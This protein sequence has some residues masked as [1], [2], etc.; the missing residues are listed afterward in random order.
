MKKIFILIAVFSS[1]L[2][3]GKG[4]LYSRYGFGEINPYISARA[5]GMGNNGIALFSET[6]IN[7]E[8]PAAIGFINRSLF[9]GA[10]QHKT[11]FST[12]G[13]LSS[14]LLSGNIQAAAIAFPLYKPA[15]SVLALSLRPLSTMGYNLT[16]KSTL[17]ANTITQT[18]DGRG[19]LTS[20]QI[21][22]SYEAAEDI[23]LGGGLNYVFGAFSKDQT[24]NFTDASYFGGSFNETISMSGGRL[25]IG[26][27]IRGIDKMMQLSDERN[28]NVGFSLYS[29]TTL[30]TEN[31]ILRNFSS[32]TD[33]VTKLSLKSK[34]PLSVGLGISYSKN[35]IVYTGDFYFQNWDAGTIAGKSQNEL[36][37]SIRAGIGAEFLPSADFTDEFWKRVSYRIGGF[38]Q[39]TSI[40]LNGQSINEI[41]GSAG[42]SFP[43][44]TESRLHLGMEYGIRGTTSSLLYKDTILRFTAAVTISELMFIPPKVD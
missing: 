17:G 15:K 37:N 44:S 35:N 36:Q 41:F 25:V 34:L 31:E 1:L 22:I 14:T 4:S 30:D 13:K 5:V 23:I 24:I 26:G 39:Q 6:D 10:Y 32:N 19:G 43:I 40:Q 12:D 18:F 33:T 42:L 9:S 38:M 28:L 11:Y 20:A 21:S 3:A 27:L 2:F 16:A 29:G 8:N 7:L